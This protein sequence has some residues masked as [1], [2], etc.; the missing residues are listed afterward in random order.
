MF[1][2][3]YQVLATTIPGKTNRVLVL[4]KSIVDAVLPLLEAFLSAKIL[5]YSVISAQQKRI[6]E[7]IFIFAGLL[8]ITDLA[9]RLVAF[10]FGILD[11]KI[12]DEAEL[13]IGMSLSSKT[14]RIEYA[15][16]EDPDFL[17]LSDRSEQFKFRAGF[18]TR[19]ITNQ[20]LYPFFSFLAALI[21]FITISKLAALLIVLISIPFF[22]YRLKLAKAE[23]R[24]WDANWPKARKADSYLDITGPRYI[25]ESRVLGLIDYARKKWWDLSQEIITSNRKLN[26]KTEKL[27]ILDGTMSTI[28]EYTLLLFVIY[29][30]ARGELEIG[31]FIFAQTLIKRFLDSIQ[32]ISFGVSMVDEDVALLS[33]YIKFMDLPEEPISQL[34]D[35]PQLLQNPSIKIESLSFNYPKSKLKVLEN[36]DLEIPF[37]KDIAIVGENGAGKTTL[38]KLILGLYKP[39]EGQI[40][41]N[42]NNLQEYSSKEWHKKVGV[43]FQDF[44]GFTDFKIEDAVWFGDVDK[45]KS[46]K[47]IEQSLQKSGALKFVNKLSAKTKTYMNKWIDENAG[48]E[49]SG[50]QLQ[51]VALARSF[52]RDPDILILDEPTSAIDAKGEYE[53]FKILEEERKDKTNIFI[54]HRFNTVRKADIIYFIE[55]GRIVES[56]NHQELVKLNG[57]YAEL[58]EKYAKDYR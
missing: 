44:N 4:S 54:S 38:V 39:R 40:H 47:M 53:I 50:G 29:R 14:S 19:Q 36:I 43:L 2:K 12:Q 41:I 51:R 57:K 17:K 8:I 26:I 11:K 20:I 37:G 46:K 28:L 32:S 30:I 16:Y 5:N 25:K 15:S 45:P 56:G 6:D 18:L 49:L 10:Y 21:A 23:R 3:Y 31:Y 22:L 42:Q 55:D 1:K 33:D 24:L 48:T 7:G 35:Q 34:E 27:N 13:N 58:F 52:F 9:R